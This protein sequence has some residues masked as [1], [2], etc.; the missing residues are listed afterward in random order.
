MSNSVSVDSSDTRARRIA[1][2]LF[3]HQVE[4]MAFLLGRRRALLADDMGLGKTR[5][6]IVALRVHASE[7]PYLVVCPASVKHNWAREIGL[8]LE[9]DDVLVLDGSTPPPQGSRRRVEAPARWVVVN[10]D[11][12]TKHTDWLERVAWGG[13]VFDEAHYLKNQKSARSRRATGLAKAALAFDEETAIFALTGTPLTN[14]PRDLFPL[15]QLLGHPMGR[16]F[17]SFAKRY[18]AAYRNDYGWVTDGASNLE[19]LAVQL[20]GTLLRRTKDDVLDLPPKLR[21]YLPVDVPE[22]TGAD[23]TR[24]VVRTLIEE[25]SGAGR[26]RR[27]NGGSAAGGG[28]RARLIATIT[29]VRRQVAVAK[30]KHTVDLVESAVEQGE[31]VLVFSCFDEPVQRI[32]SHFGDRALVL[33]GATPSGKRQEI[34]DRFQSDDGAPVLVANIIAGGVGLNLTAAGQVVFN[35]LDWVPANHWQAEDRAYRIGQTRTVNVSYLIACGTIDEFVR[36]VLEAKTLLAEAVVDGRAIGDAITRVVLAELEAVIASLSPG[37]ADTAL[38]DVDKVEVNRLLEA[39]SAEVRA[40]IRNRSPETTETSFTT[41]LP[42][43]AFERALALL[44]DVLGGPKARRW[45]IV[46]NSKPGVFYELEADSG[47]D[48]ICNCP[49]FEYRGACSHA[50]QLKAGLAKGAVPPAFQGVA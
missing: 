43:A 15:L 42:D 27:H 14:R 17:L 23:A 31:K 32:A 16:S 38:E 24:R 47:G 11:I 25:R 49:G 1:R 29:T 28:G 34:V 18:C 30:A 19:E 41:G 7:G 50:R 46:S 13:I 35:D 36:D 5:Q 22:G 9:G 21:T 39:A 44:A 12:L 48:V 4:G 6:A 37:L 2:G 33:T 26:A 20:H 40:R 45:R 8:A 3:P 10:Y